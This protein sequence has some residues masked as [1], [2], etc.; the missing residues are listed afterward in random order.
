MVDRLATLKHDFE[1]LFRRQQ[2]YVMV[3]EV[4]LFQSACGC[5]GLRVRPGGFRT[6]VLDMQGQQ[7][8]K[9]LIDT[10]S[11]CGVMPNLGYVHLVF[12]SRDLIDCLYMVDACPSCRLNIEESGD[13]TPVA[14]FYKGMQNGLDS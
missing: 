3:D 6:N 7:I 2:K 11:K 14:I 13:L 12:G 1:I 4:G 8:S 10:C 5:H 9:L